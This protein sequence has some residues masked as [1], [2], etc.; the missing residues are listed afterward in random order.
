MGP[1]HVVP[2]VNVNPG[3]GVWAQ[4]ML[5][6][7]YTRTSTF[8]AETTRVTKQEIHPACA[9]EENGRLVIVR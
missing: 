6:D 8:A 4:R 7:E 5:G 1:N 9:L 3:V 2:W